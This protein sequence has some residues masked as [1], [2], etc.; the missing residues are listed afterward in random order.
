MDDALKKC[1]RII[2]VLSRS[3]LNKA[4]FSASEWSAAFRDDPTGAKGKIIPVK[5]DDCEPEGLLASLTYIDLVETDRD[6]ARDR[7]LD[8]VRQGRG[9]PAIQPQFPGRSK[10]HGP[11]PDFPGMVRTVAYDPSFS[12]SDKQVII[13]MLGANELD[14]QIELLMRQTTGDAYRDAPISAEINRLISQRQKLI[15]QKP[16]TVSFNDMLKTVM[17]SYNKTKR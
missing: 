1:R 14:R 13:G 11:E 10:A 15:P 5:V 17:E 3:Y 8:G 16:K 12:D 6:T 7:L 2:A 4:P 9:K